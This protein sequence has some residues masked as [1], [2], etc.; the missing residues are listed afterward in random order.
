[1]NELTEALLQRPQQRRAD[2]VEVFGPHAVADVAGAEP[3][4]ER[5]DTLDVAESVDGGLDS[6]HVP[7]GLQRD[8]VAE[9]RPRPRAPA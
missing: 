2:E 4:E 7:C 3:D 8:V 5:S 9:Q 6:R 1:M